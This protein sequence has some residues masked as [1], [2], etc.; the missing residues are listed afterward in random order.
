VFDRRLSLTVDYFRSKNTDL[1]L[2]VNI[3]AITGFYT[4][5]KNIGEVQN[6][7]LEVT[8]TSVNVRA[9]D[10]QWS[11][12]F[13]VSVY[14]NKVNKLGP[15]G[16][17]IYSASNV[18]LVGQPIGMFYGFKTNGVYLSQGDIDKSPIFGE[19]TSVQSRPGDVKYVDVNGDGK[20]DNGDQTI[21]G[22]PYPDFYYGMTNRLSYKSISLSVTL[23][24]TQG[25]QVLNMAA[26]GQ[27]NTRANRVSQLASQINYWKSEAD[28]GNGKTPRPNDA[29]TGNNR[30]VSQRYLDTGSFLRITN[31]TLGY[32]LPG[33][34]VNRLH[35]KS[36]RVYA[37]ATNALTFSR[38]TVSFNPDVS[39]SGSPLNPGVDFNDYPL[40]KTFTLGINI[41]F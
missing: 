22:N 3:P 6:K 15:G 16:D 25:N 32:L 33:G 2:N 23:Q 21:M 4:A 37:N 19:G 35:L 26:I 34:L 39:N 12:D 29:V 36:W 10:F 40:P 27:E 41:G 1:L 38:N 14:R 20:I 13:N 8:L 7:G 9:R 30:A 11:T 5:L 17:P 24:G 31:I 28:P 18:T